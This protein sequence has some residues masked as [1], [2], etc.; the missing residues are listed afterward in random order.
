MRV[1]KFPAVFNPAAMCDDSNFLSNAL[2]IIGNL[3]H[4]PERNYY[5]L[6]HC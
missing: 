3:S 1:I 5:A 6:D 2:H 4:F